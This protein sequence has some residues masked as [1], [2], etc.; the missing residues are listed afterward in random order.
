MAGK[1]AIGK[2]S[3][4]EFQFNLKAGNG[5][6][7]LTSQGYADKAG[8]KNGIESVR[9]NSQDDGKFERKVSGNGKPYFNL[10][11][12]NGQIVGTSEM[13]ESAAAR[14]N[15]I[16]SVKKNAPDAAVVDETA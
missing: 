10:L 4:G 7:I 12:G 16:E 6:T 11:A 5:Q 9:K 2:R 8:A 14:D 15:G 1:F 3:N 13:Y